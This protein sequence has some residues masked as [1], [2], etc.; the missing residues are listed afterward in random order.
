MY[1]LLHTNTILSS[2]GV[3]FPGS[4]RRPP[5]IL[6]APVIRAS[7]RSRIG[8][9]L[10]GQLQMILDR[11]AMA[12]CPSVRFLDAVIDEGLNLNYCAQYI[13]W[14]LHWE[15][16][17]VSVVQSLAKRMWQ[18]FGLME[19]ISNNSGCFLVWIDSED[20]IKV[21]DGGSWH[22]ASCP[23]LSK[24][25]DLGMSLSQ[26]TRASLSR[27]LGLVWLYIFF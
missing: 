17:F 4:R 10:S 19:M 3:W 11:S 26:E 15:T 13:G 23:L 12:V 14:V 21:F 25:W 16:P 6:I 18:R 2:E 7:C 27:Y 22:L 20:M 5:V 24:I 1:I 9:R 8:P